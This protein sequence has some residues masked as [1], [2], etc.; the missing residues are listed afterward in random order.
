[1]TFEIQQ[2]GKFKYV[3][4]GQG[5]TIVL[6]HGLFGA[7]S[8]F[9][10]L[11]N[12]FS[13]NYRVVIPLLPLYELPVRQTT[14]DGLVDYVLEFIEFKGYKQV[15]YVGNSL[16]GHVGLIC[17]LENQE[18][19]R[20]LI[21]TGS[22]G[23]FEKAFGDTYP[24]RKNYEFIRNRTA[25]TFYDPNVATKELV[26]EV[27]EIVN[28]REKALRV[29]RMAKSAVRH[30]LR[31]ELKKIHIPVLLIWGKNDIITP[32]FVAEEFHERL[33][34]ST[35][36]FIDKCGHAPMMEHPAEFNEHLDSF[37]R[38]IKEKETFN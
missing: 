9:S 32:D 23:L 20:S 1:M 13:R 8:N 34:N 22:S 7:L 5:D 19:V 31:E 10:D 15:S 6:L 35:L 25:Q 17:T 36:I 30:N 33:Q 2:E 27:F 12:H 4:C 37:L 18:N 3:A 29:L 16:G 14:V 28:N 24:K 11:I 26:D 21:L 38:H